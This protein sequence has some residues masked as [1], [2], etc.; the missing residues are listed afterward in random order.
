MLAAVSSWEPEGPAGKR[1][2]LR[3]TTCVDR[4]TRSGSPN[5]RKEHQT[6]NGYDAL[7]HASRV[8]T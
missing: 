6:V 7:M 8:S 5:G 4:T 3:P 2:D 1:G